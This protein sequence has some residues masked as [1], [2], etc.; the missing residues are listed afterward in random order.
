MCGEPLP[1]SDTVERK[2]KEEK[3]E[4]YI[5]NNNN[6]SNWFFIFLILFLTVCF[7]ILLT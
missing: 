7:Y 1:V 6:F 4:R 3:I 2:I 5:K